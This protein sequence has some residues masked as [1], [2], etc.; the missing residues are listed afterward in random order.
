MRNDAFTWDTTHSYET[1]CRNQ[2]CRDVFCRTECCKDESCLVSMRHVSYLWVMSHNKALRSRVLQ[3]WVLQRWVMSRIHES[4]LTI[5]LCRVVF[6]QRCVTFACKWSLLQ[7]KILRDQS[8]CG[9]R[10]HV[11]FMES[12]TFSIR[13]ASPDSPVFSSFRDHVHNGHDLC[14][15]HHI[16]GLMCTGG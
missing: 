13:Y 11:W 6:S 15:G 1:F 5:R 12:G 8:H 2:F 4:C 3:K 7:Q 10:F 16:T 14:K 9:I